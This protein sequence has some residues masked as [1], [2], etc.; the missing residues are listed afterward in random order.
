MRRRLDNALRPWP[1]FFGNFAGP[2]S[3]ARSYR[4]PHRTGAFCGIPAASPKIGFYLERLLPS[5]SHGKL[6][7]ANWRPAG[8][9]VFPSG[10]R[11][12]HALIPVRAYRVQPTGSKGGPDPQ[13]ATK[14]RTGT[15]ATVR[16]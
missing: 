12:P 7:A 16:E 15:P 2:R 3:R 8:V 5:V 10:R 6:R 13:L 1:P 4:P 9:A 11:V 14:T